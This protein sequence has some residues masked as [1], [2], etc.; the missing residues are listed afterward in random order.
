MSGGVLP[1]VPSDQLLDPSI[2]FKA[3]SPSNDFT[4]ELLKDDLFYVVASVYDY[5][6]FTRQH[7]AV[8]LWRTRM[9]I[10]AGGVTQ[11]QTL[12]TLVMSASPYFGRETDGA[13]VLNRQMTEKIEIGKPQV[14]G[15]TDPA[16]GK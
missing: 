6:A 4:M 5:Q 1:P 12:P 2:P 14:L 8:L 15:Y 13:I 16:A 3:K 11:H 7:K 9:A 10:S